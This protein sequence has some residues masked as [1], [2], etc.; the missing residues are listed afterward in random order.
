LTLNPH[1]I[2][3][4]HALQLFAG[5]SGGL[6]LHACGQASDRASAPADKQKTTLSLGVIA[7]IGL[8]PVFIAQEKGFFEAEGV[9]LDLKMFAANAE[10]IPAFVSNNLDSMSAVG[11]ETL[12]V[13]SQGKDFR[14]VMIEDSS[15][16]ADGILARNSI[17]SIADFKGKKIAVDTT[18]VS[19]FFLLQVLQEA[20]LKKDD[21]SPVPMDAAAA[22]TA[23]QAGNVDIAVTYAPFL[24]Q[25]NK[26]TTDGR[27]IYDSTKMPTAITDMY[28]FSSEFIE[29]N[30][31]AV[32][33]F[34]NGV[35]KGIQF[36]NDNP[37]EGLAIA[38]KALEIK[39]EALA[40]D[41]K[42]IKLTDL[43][44]NQKMLSDPAS[45]VYIMKSLQELANFLVDQGEIDAVPADLDKILDPQ[46]VKAAT[47]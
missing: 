18:S 43:A 29:A 42:G 47:P 6:V 20:G 10:V 24:E 23:Y 46:F 32:Q 45:D 30:P 37:D 25:A 5:L 33:G 34:I 28:L 7:W 12:L 2:R 35:F 15:L 4:R 36:L 14:I 11:T 3:R 17:A 16:G 8:S 27:I 38:A 26:A 19:Y 13:K 22:A 31:Q 1:T 9:I 21:I 44:T 40:A 39:P 41:L